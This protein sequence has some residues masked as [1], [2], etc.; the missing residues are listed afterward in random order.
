M[1]GG[2]ERG[3]GCR[4]KKKRHKRVRTGSDIVFKSL[5]IETRKEGRG[6]QREEREVRRRKRKEKGKEKR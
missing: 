3:E 1:V 5:Q 2:R 4:K 6:H